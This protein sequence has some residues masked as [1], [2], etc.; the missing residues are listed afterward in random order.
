[1]TTETA[2]IAPTPLEQR[3]AVIADL[4]RELAK[5]ID[6][7]RNVQAHLGAHA[8]ANAA[9]H[10]AGITVYS[11]LHARVTACLHDMHGASARTDPGTTPQPITNSDQLANVLEDL[12]R[13]DHGRRMGESCLDCG[14]TSAGNPRM[15][16][17]D[18]I[19][20]GLHGEIVMPQRHDARNA[21]LW[22]RAAQ[23]KHAA[24]AT[25]TTPGGVN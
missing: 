22:R 19:G 1:M 5:A 4:R 8:A 7:L 13:C 18:V 21:R 20:H 10:C 11:P 14:G 3:D 16:P 9:L 15:R 6:V 25:T 24:E 23:P 17:G 12:Y 2:T